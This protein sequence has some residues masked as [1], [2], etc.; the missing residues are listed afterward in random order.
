MRR[1]CSTIFNATYLVHVTCSCDLF[2]KIHCL[3]SYTRMYL[4]V[5]NM[6]THLVPGV[7]TSVWY[8]INL[9]RFAVGIYDT[10]ALQEQY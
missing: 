6:T 4:E 5:Y 2:G 8:R 10:L 1:A 9:K 7:Y 3:V